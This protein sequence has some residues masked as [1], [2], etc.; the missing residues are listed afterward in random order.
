[1]KIL[2][3]IDALTLGGA[4]RQM[5]GLASMLNKKGY[6][7]D[8]VYYY[9]D[10]FYES[11][12]R[13]EGLNTKYIK[14]SKSR[15]SKLY[16]MCKFVKRGKY[17]AVI[18]YKDGATTIAC[19]LKLLGLNFKLIV[20]ERNTNQGISK[21]DKVKFNL[22]KRFADFIVPNSY[23]QRSF[24]IKNFRNLEQKT[25]TIT[26]FIDTEHFIPSFN[27]RG[28]NVVKILTV[29]R[30]A[31]QKNVINYLEAAKNI[32]AQNRNVI[33]EWYGDVQP[34][35]EDY[36][37]NCMEKLYGLGIEDNF[38]FFPA[39]KNIVAI[40]QNCDI[41]CLPSSYEGYPNVICEAMSCGKP[42]L[43]SA[44]CDN[45]MIVENGLTGFMFNPSDV[46]DI[47]E[48]I[49]RILSL[50]KDD[51]VKMGANCREVSEKICSKDSFVQRYI[52]LLNK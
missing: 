16:H 36:A 42:I 12:V 39:E 40:Y 35:E 32:I 17:D 19:L 8:L 24:I 10:N 50:S 9:K 6:D 20:S 3:F 33:F 29:A 28:D 47:S 38:K 31:R 25:I 21:R 15:F 49:N 23:S 14:V 11:L 5:I 4:E 27:K 22:Y 52:D 26:N 51:F 37:K 44:V 13:S 46:C 18:A 41:F 48:K 45:P 7:I 34:G 2:C 43:C 1:M 30:I